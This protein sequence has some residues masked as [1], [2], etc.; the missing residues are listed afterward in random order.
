MPFNNRYVV[1]AMDT[2][3]KQIAVLSP[4]LKWTE[5]VQA[6][7]C[8]PSQQDA[9]HFIAQNSVCD[10][11]FSEADELNNDASDNYDHVQPVFVTVESNDATESEHVP[12]GVISFTGI[13]G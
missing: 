9:N 8:F 13:Y 7:V 2:S 6:A 1:A 11:A 5:S 10:I 3:G 4:S 12:E